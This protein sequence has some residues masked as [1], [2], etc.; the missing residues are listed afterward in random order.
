MEKLHFRMEDLE[1]VNSEDLP[2]WCSGYAAVKLIIDHDDISRMML[3]G[4]ILDKACPC[5]WKAVKTLLKNLGIGVVTQ[6]VVGCIAMHPGTVNV[7]AKGLREALTPL[8]PLTTPF[9]V[10]IS[11]PLPPPQRLNPFAESNQFVL[12]GDPFNRVGSSSVDLLCA[13]DKEVIVQKRAQVGY[14]IN[15]DRKVLMDQLDLMERKAASK[16]NKKVRENH[17]ET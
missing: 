17:D 5:H 3:R 8:T 1:E 12:G 4:R 11:Q 16:H 7:V 15:H 14:L 9:V 10:R 6:G 2:L 13:T